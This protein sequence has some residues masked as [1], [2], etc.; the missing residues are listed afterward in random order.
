MNT[1]NGMLRDYPP[2][3]TVASSATEAAKTRELFSTAT[4]ICPFSPP[5][6]NAVA[7]TE[8]NVAALAEALTAKVFEKGKVK[9]DRHWHPIK[10]KL[11]GAGGE[12]DAEPETLSS[13][14]Q[15]KRQRHGRR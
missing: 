10:A 4:E 8:E 2:E 11:A 13:F 6:M 3:K 14:L 9:G 1:T 5:T 12:Q 15:K 7:P